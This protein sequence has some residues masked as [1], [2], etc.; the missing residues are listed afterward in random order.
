MTREVLRRCLAN[1]IDRWAEKSCRELREL[2]KE[3]VSYMNQS[4]NGSY[5]AEVSLLKSR[6]DY[7]QVAVSVDD[8]SMWKTI[9]PVSASFVVYEDGRTER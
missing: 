9:M 5:Q 4:E 7:C 2:L 1:E 3:P 8:Q 6:S